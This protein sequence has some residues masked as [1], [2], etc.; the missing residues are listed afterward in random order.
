MKGIKYIAVAIMAISLALNLRGQIA[1][2]DNLTPRQL[3]K[4][5]VNAERAGDVF[6]A[7]FFY[8]K[9]REYFAH[10]NKVNYQLANLHLHVRNYHDALKLYEEVLKGGDDKYPMARFYYA[11]MLK[12]TGNYDEAIVEFNKFR[13]NYKE[14]KDSRDLSRI[15]RN[16][17]EGCDSAKKI[18]SNPLNINIGYMNESVNSPHIELSPIPLD[19]NTFIYGSLRVDSLVYFT[20]EN[21]DT[22]IPVRQ[23]YV[24]R[25]QGMDWMGGELMGAPINLPGVETGNGVL[26]RDGKRFYFS[27]SVKNWQGKVIS[28]IYRST[29]IE[30]VWSEPEKL[31]QVIN[32]PNY[33]TTQPAL[34][35]TAQSDREIVFFVSD[36]PGGRGGL[37][38]WY[39]VWNSDKDAYS[40]PRNLGSKINTFGDEITPYYDIPT[41]TLYFSS[42]GLPGIGGFDVFSAFGER[43]DWTRIKNIGYPVNSSF[44]DLYFT[45]SR[46]G[47]DG[48]FVSNRPDS[49]NPATCCDDIFYYSWNDYVRITVTGIIYPFEK[50]RFGRKRDLSGFDFMNP[51]ASV[52]PMK[53]AIIALYMLDKELNDYVFMDR[54]VTSENGRFYFNLQPNE[55]YEFRM[56]GFQYFDEKN[57][58]STQFFNFSDTIEMPPIWINVLTDKPI[59]LENVYYDFNSADLSQKAK[60]VLDTTLL[61]LLKEAPEF[62]IEIGSHTD[63]IGEA[64]YNLELS[65]QRAENVVQYLISK[66][67]PTQRLVAKGYGATKPVAPNFMADGSDNPVGREKNRRTEFRIVGTLGGSDDEEEFIYD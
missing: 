9:Y 65:Q 52:E 7:I 6:T 12:S 21:I 32:D 25:K 61:V 31:P 58:M 37:D 8:E 27:R 48:F 64:K 16:E 40:K 46:E 17:I 5:A 66:G 41:R 51:D 56:E 39:S 34:G 49:L 30:G 24:A 14:E 4:F 36:R 1:D 63:S 60:S 3:K 20:S 33:T 18:I 38:I 55:E 11:Q 22:E 47:G 57:F 35:R 26:S 67:I 28:S 53:N 42:T 44:D 2:I 29:K 23:F 62:I 10:N 13:K 19:A 50:D 15:I 43:K 45:V 59:V 54:Y